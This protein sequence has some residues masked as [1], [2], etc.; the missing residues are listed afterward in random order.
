M[1]TTTE[2]LP[3]RVIGSV[4]VRPMFEVLGNFADDWRDAARW[5][6]PLPFH[7]LENE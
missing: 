6:E 5:P 1:S 2:E 3:A 7:D 4:Y